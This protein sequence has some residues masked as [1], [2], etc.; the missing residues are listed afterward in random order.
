MIIRHEKIGGV[1]KIVEIDESKFGKRKYHR[2]HRVEMQWIFGGVERGSGKC[3]LMP[4]EFRNKKTLLTIIKQWILLGTNIISDCWKSYDC[5]KHE[6]YVHLTVNHSINFKDLETDAHT[7]NV[8]GMWRH[9]KAS[10]TK[11]TQYSRKKHFYAGYMKKCMF[12]KQ[13]RAKKVEPLSAFFEFAGHLYSAAAHTENGDYVIAEDSDSFN[14][15][16]G[17]GDAI[18][19]RGLPCE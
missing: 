17:G 10:L 13:F 2:G 16:D 19:S 6:G 15:D 8:E 5:L 3:F 7:N 18:P 14:D 1:D 9:A 4:A 11:Y 12:L